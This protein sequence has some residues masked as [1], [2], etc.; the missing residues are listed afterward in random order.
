MD[1]RQLRY[2]AQIAESGNVSRAAE[3][4][5]IAQPSLSQQM[6]NLEDELGVALLFRHAQIGR[7]HV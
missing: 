6:R 2:F 7:A 5:R 1:L 4:L 3:V